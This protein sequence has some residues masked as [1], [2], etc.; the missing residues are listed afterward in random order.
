MRIRSSGAALEANINVTPLVDVCLV[1]LIIFM[2]VTP[3][4]VSG[5]QVNLPKT[6][7]G[8]QLGKGEMLKVN[9]NADGTV[10]LN[11]LAIRAEKVRSEVERLHTG[12]PDMRVD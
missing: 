5:V 8:T 7:T 3:V 9:V 1:L 4:I 11:G 2:V 10:Y 6:H 12:A